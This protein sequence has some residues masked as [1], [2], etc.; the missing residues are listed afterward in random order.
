MLFPVV[1]STL[2]AVISACGVVL[3]QAIIAQMAD[4]RAFQLERLTEVARTR[5]GHITPQAAAE[6]LSVSVLEADA[7]LRRL[8]NTSTMRMRVDERRGELDFWLP[9]LRGMR[10]DE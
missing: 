2:A 7:L 6:A 3:V 1:V 5:D 10:V 8:V 9:E 4:R